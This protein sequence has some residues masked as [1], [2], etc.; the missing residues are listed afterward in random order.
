MRAC[1]P[2]YLHM[3]PSLCWVL[4]TLIGGSAYIDISNFSAFTLPLTAAYLFNHSPNQKNNLDSGRGDLDLSFGT[5]VRSI[6]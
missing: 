2:Y 4:K 3:D 6:T 1:V 5:F